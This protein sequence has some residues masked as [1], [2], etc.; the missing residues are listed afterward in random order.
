MFD[1]DDVLEVA[2]NDPILKT[3]PTQFVF[4]SS[5]PNE[6]TRCVLRVKRIVSTGSLNYRN[7]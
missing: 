2:L 5:A 1:V 4:A 6:P 7:S 3:A